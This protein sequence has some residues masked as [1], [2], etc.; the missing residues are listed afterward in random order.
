MPMVK[1]TLGQRLWSRLKGIDH[2]VMKPID[3]H[4]RF[5]GQRQILKF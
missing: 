5:T 4:D 2:P 1:M 3:F